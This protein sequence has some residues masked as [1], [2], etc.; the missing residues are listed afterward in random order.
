MTEPRGLKRQRLDVRDNK[1]GESLDEFE[2]KSEKEDIGYV[3]LP[4]VAP[5][6]KVSNRPTD[7]GEGT[8]SLNHLVCIQKIG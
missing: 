5:P 4:F 7:M 2:S 6:Q 3:L 8:R 1:E